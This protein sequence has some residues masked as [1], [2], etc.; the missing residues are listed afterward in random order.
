M[1]S[2]EAAVGRVWDERGIAQPKAGQRIYVPIAI[3]PGVQMP[4]N[5]NAPIPVGAAY[6]PRLPV[7]YNQPVMNAKPAQKTKHHEK[8]KDSKK[9]TKKKRTKAL[10]KR[11]GK[12]ADEKA[13]D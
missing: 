13:R 8:S 11:P 5:P 7:K 3:P 4:M 12:D 6:Y 2:L 10:S 9:R 1:G